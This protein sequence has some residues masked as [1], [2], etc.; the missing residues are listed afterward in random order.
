M[1]NKQNILIF[2][3]PLIP[4]MFLILENSKKQKFTVSIKR[5]TEITK[6]IQQELIVIGKNVDEALMEV[7]NF[8]DKSILSN[9][10]EVRI[11]HGKGLRILS[12]AI[13]NYL[14]TDKRVDSFRFGKYGEGEDGVT[15]VK[16]K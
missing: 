11:V 3:S 12:K 8:I 6:T 10:D 14:K 7:E 5:S 15:I 1:A 2:H 16:L 13:Q 4:L 9:L